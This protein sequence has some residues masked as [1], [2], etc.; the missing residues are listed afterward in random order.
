MVLRIVVYAKGWLEVFG[1]VCAPS[2]C[3]EILFETGV[4][5]E[6]A[7]G[8]HDCSAT[9]GAHLRHTDAKLQAVVLLVWFRALR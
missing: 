6:E 4:Q 7:L 5:D 3:S 8:G 1:V 2:L 9:A